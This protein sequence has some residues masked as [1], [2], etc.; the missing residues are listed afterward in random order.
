MV[1]EVEQ[2]GMTKRGAI[3]IYGRPN[4][5]ILCI[6]PGLFI[7]FMLILPS[8]FVVEKRKRESSLHHE[9]SASGHCSAICNLPPVSKQLIA[10]SNNIIVTL[11]FFPSYVAAND[12][13]TRDLWFGD[14]KTKE[15][16][17]PPLLQICL[18]THINIAR[19]RLGLIEN[20]NM[21]MKSINIDE[22]N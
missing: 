21:S 8:L 10:A 18:F 14:F 3:A 7:L 19:I 2:V 13:R 11:R 5:R 9:S 12:I 17:T 1:K 22:K 20:R 4:Q 15:N 6:A 16:D